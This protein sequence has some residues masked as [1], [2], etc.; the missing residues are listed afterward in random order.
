MNKN[1]TNLAPGFFTADQI[2]RMRMSTGTTAIDELLDGGLESGLTHLFYGQRSLHDDLLKMAV[3]AQKPVAQGGIGSPTIIIDSANM[4]KI[5]RLTDFAFDF[6]LEPE[7]VMNNIYITR[8][9]N[10][11][12]TYDLVMNQLESFFERV[13]ARLLLITGFP[14]LYLKEGIT[15]EAAQELTHMATRLMT[16][17]LKKGIFTAISAPVSETLKNTPAGGKALASCAQV[18]VFVEE[19]K[20]YFRYTLAKHPNLQVRHTSRPKPVMFGT[21][22]PLSHFLKPEE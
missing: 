19:F 5:E 20:S 10:S 3:H 8:A 6:E 18:H 13:P 16:L 11:S 4:L 14:D 2:V 12:Q 15:G 22:L 1:K 9:F 17:T 21:T 7:I